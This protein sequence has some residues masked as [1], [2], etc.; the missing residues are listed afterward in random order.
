MDSLVGERIST[1][2]Q[3]VV[4]AMVTVKQ[5]RSEWDWEGGFSLRGCAWRGPNYEKESES[6]GQEEEHSRQEPGTE[7]LEAGTEKRCAQL[8]CSSRV[9]DRD[10]GQL[11]L[12][13]EDC[14]EPERKHPKRVCRG[15]MAVGA[16]WRMAGMREWRWEGG[17]VVPPTDGS[18]ASTV[19]PLKTQPGGNERQRGRVPVLPA[20]VLVGETDNKQVEKEKERM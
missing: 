6:E 12:G 8:E 5:G 9:G 3:T 17:P 11:P 1:T 18:G 4:S 10:R 7:I 20:R 14:W 2:F 16:V 19:L 15:Q 13:L